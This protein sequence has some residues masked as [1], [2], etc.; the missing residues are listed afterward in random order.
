MFDIVSFLAALAFAAYAK[1]KGRTYMWGVH[2]FLI[3]LVLQIYSAVSG[4]GPD[5]PMRT[6]YAFVIAG[7]LYLI[8]G[9]A[10]IAADREEKSKEIK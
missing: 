7:F 10:A 3:V 1:N 4:G 6:I 2:P 9:Q 5:E 8:A